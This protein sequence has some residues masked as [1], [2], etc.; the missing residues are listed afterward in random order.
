MSDFGEIGRGVLPM[1]DFYEVRIGIKFV[2]NT[3]LIKHLY[4][5]VYRPKSSS[6]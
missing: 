4:S 6:P 2:F 1:F 5:K 3:R